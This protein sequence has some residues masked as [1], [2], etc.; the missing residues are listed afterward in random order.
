MKIEPFTPHYL[1]HTFAT[2]LYLQDINVVD[3]MQIL[4]HSD[5][6]TTIN[7]YTDFKNLKK[8][9]LS[10]KYKEHLLSDYAIK[11]A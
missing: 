6:Q 10:K 5:V 4:G 2:M 9:N 8:D 1:R 3:A 11:T 7:I